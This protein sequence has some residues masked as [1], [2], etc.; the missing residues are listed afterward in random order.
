MSAWYNYAPFCHDEKNGARYH[1]AERD[2]SQLCSTTVTIF[3][4]H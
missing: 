2:S 1:V 4:M 3:N